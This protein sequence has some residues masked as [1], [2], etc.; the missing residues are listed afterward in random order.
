[1]MTAVRVFAV[2]L[3]GAA[4]IGMAQ[5]DQTAPSL[6]QRGAS[7][8]Q[9][10]TAPAPTD[11][12]KGYSTLPDNASGEYELDDNGSVVQITVEDNRLSGYVTNMDEGSAQTLLFQRTTI[13]GDRLT[14]TTQTV[15]GV[16][17]GFTGIVTRGDEQ[18]PAKPGYF[19]LAGDWTEYHDG[20]QQTKSVRLKSTPRLPHMAD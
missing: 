13:Q 11:Y 15:H 16:S 7:A 5:T 6:K 17:Y 14:F 1:M 9:R 4:A 8:S 20:G 19:R 3:M 12:A 10:E 18:S 2:L